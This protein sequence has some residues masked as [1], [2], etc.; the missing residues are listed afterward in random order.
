M[1]ARP[2]V[3][4]TEASSGAGFE[5]EL[6]PERSGCGKSA[7]SLLLHPPFGELLAPTIVGQ[8]DHPEVAVCGVGVR[9]PPANETGGAGNGHDF[10]PE[11]PR[12]LVVLAAQ[13]ALHDRLAARP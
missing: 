4:N 3:P 11:R 6:W 2:T 10:E 13:P 7:T 1:W 5:R 12:A 8:S 9:G